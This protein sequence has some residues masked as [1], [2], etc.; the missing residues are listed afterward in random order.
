MLGSGFLTLNLTV[1]AM[2]LVASI[3]TFVIC[4]LAVA[5]LDVRNPGKMQNFVEWVIEFVRG[6]ANDF[7]APKY[8]EKFVPMA[9][10][11]MLYLFIANQMGV[12]FNFNTAIE[13]P[14]P[15]VAGEAYEHAAGKGHAIVS[16]WLS[17]TANTSVPI[18][19]ALGVFLLSH[20]IGL[21]HPKEYFS[22]FKNPMHLIEEITKPVTHALRL[23]GNIFAG[24]VL[25]AVIIMIPTLFGFVPV[26]A[27]PLIVWLG[28]SLFVG[29]IQAFVFT[30][31]T[32]LYV[33]QKLPNENH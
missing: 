14:I 10:T 20:G 1:A 17:P 2:I 15:F 16:W 5:K 22:H 3:I 6:L 26:G 33:G 7:M 21:R 25:M 19:L 4:R 11:L 27:I 24:E 8:A 28:Y 13:H 23:W 29:T 18:A 12:I 30:I 31:L 9:V 32:L